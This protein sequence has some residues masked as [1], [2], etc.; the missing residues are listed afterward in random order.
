MQR[1]GKRYR[2]GSSGPRR[3]ARVDW[4]TRKATGEAYANGYTDGLTVWS[5]TRRGLHSVDTPVG[6]D[7]EAWNAFIADHADD[8]GPGGGEGDDGPGGGAGVDGG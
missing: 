3:T 6:I 4:T 1:N 8:F 7:Q 5:R 2:D